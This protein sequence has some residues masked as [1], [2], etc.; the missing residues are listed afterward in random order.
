[1]NKHRLAIVISGILVCSAIAGWWLMQRS[2]GWSSGPLGL[3]FDDPVSV[4]ATYSTG[5]GERELWVGGYFLATNKGPTSRVARIGDKT[6]HR[7]PAINAPVRSFLPFNDDGQSRMYV[8]GQFT[9]IHSRQ[10]HFITMFDGE[11]WQSLSTG[12]NDWVHALATF[13]DGH[14]VSL[15][16]AGALDTFRSGMARAGIHSVTD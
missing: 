4:L 7:A 10:H 9:R 11:Q 13:D 15:Y 3:G 2:C 16:A 12:M 8:G 1:M 14:G 5:A 6:W